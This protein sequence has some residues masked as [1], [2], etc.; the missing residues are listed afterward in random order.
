MSTW[1]SAELS[2]LRQLRDDGLTVPE[3]ADALGKRQ[4]DIC[5]VCQIFGIPSNLNPD[6]LNKGRY[7]MRDSH[8]EQAAVMGS[9]MLRDAILR[10]F[11]KREQASQ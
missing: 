10:F 1:S 6:T 8:V 3:I 2:K 7:I 11:E 4:G 5:E 9:A